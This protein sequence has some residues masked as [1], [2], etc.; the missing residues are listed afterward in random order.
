[1]GIVGIIGGSGLTQLKNLEILW[2]RVVRTPYGEASGPLTFGRLAGQEVIFLARHG[3]GHTIPPHR[4]NYRA[5]IWAL[6][7]AGVRHVIAV[8][9]VGGIA[10]TMVPGALCAPDQLIDYTSGRPNTFYEGGDSS[11]IHVDFS[12]PYCAQIR[13]RLLAAGE[14]IAQPIVAGGTYAI[15]QGPRLETAAEIRRIE[16]DGGDIVGMT[17]MPEAVL[18]REI[19]LCYAPLALVVNPAAGKSAE[20]IT[21][22][23]IDQVM[24]E[25]MERVRRVLAATVPLLAYCPDCNCGLAVGPEALQRLHH[26]LFKQATV[27]ER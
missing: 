11:V 27:Q 19:G 21:M 17:G 3:Y 8:G 18:A 2:R 14:R 10:A 23:A 12:M 13:Q 1:L 26:S 7:H 22:A 15:T 9:A 24:H 4:V 25:G 20:P 6:H 16:R 5:N